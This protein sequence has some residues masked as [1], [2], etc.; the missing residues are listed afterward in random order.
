[1]GPRP[2]VLKVLVVAKLLL[3]RNRTGMDPQNQAYLGRLHST[4]K[5]WKVEEKKL[6]CLGSCHR[7]AD[8]AN[9]AGTK[10]CPQVHVGFVLH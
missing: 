4:K 5:T 7:K 10:T 6:Q 1:M 9:S 8:V 2:C 3:G